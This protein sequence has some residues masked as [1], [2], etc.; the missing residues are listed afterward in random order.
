MRNFCSTHTHTKVYCVLCTYK[1]H[2][3]NMLGDGGR[4]KWCFA[5]LRCIS[6]LWLNDVL[7]TVH[8]TVRVVKGFNRKWLYTVWC[9]II[10]NIPQLFC[11]ATNIAVRSD[12]SCS[13]LLE[14]VVTLYWSVFTFTLIVLACP[15]LSTVQ[16]NPDLLWS[17]LICFKTYLD[18]FC[19]L[20]PGF[21]VYPFWYDFPW[22]V[23]YTNMFWPDLSWHILSWTIYARPVNLSLHVLTGPNKSRPV[24]TCPDLF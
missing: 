21:F 24:Q 3:K 15:D 7:H 22:P 16:S 1:K 4:S 19:L 23:L 17:I 18:L 14:P 11:M 12:L 2:V 6:M 13:D 10:Y 8:C 5:E 9:I 20:C